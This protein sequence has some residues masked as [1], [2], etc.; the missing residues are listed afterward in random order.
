MAYKGSPSSSGTFWNVSDYPPDEIIDSED[1]VRALARKR[2]AI[3]CLF[4]DDGKLLEIYALN[5]VGPIRCRP[6]V[7]SI[8]WDEGIW[9]N[10]ISYTINLTT[11]TVETVGASICESGLVSPALKR[12]SEEWQIEDND[13]P[14]SFRLTHILSAV[15]KLS[16]DSNGNEIKGWRNAQNWVLPR[17][18]LDN[19]KAMSSGVHNL[20]SYYGGFNYVRGNRTN[21]IDGSYEVTESWILSSGNYLED[22]TVEKTTA[23][24]GRITIG[25]QGSVEGLETRNNTNWNPRTGIKYDAANTAFNTVVDPNM[26]NRAQTYGGV[27]VNPE[28]INKTVGKNPVTGTI[29]YNYSFNDRPSNITSAKS[30]S[31]QITDHNQSDVFAEIAVIGRTLGPVLQSL[32]ATTAK[33]RDLNIELVGEAPKYGSGTPVEINTDPIVATY[34]PIA[35]FVLF[36]AQDTKSFDVKQNR[37]TR[38]VSWT[39]E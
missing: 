8:V 18:G 25:V 35:S 5:G 2:A 6:K 29:N 12:S 31:I 22:F 36:K 14:D 32:N 10:K 39:Y 15:G 16:Y 9:Y 34:I 3:D 11:D 21:E 4:A 37:T 33:R 17:L 23:E 19:E 26:L 24:D 13:K 27:T 28:P 1:R 38:Q 7:Q 20:P 30:E